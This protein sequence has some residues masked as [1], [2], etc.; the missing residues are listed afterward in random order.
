MFFHPL[1]PARQSLDEHREATGTVGCP[2]WDVEPICGSWALT[3]LFLHFL[4]PLLRPLS[5]L[6]NHGIQ[7]SLAVPLYCSASHGASHRCSHSSSW[8]VLTSVCLCS[9][10]IHISTMKLTG[11]PLEQN[12]TCTYLRCFFLCLVL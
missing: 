5:L 11:I 2:Q 6:T 3:W 8:W 9:V 7:E 10:L 12:E 4:E 1:K